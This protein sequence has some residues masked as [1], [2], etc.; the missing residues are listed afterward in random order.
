MRVAGERR[1]R[2]AEQATA[3]GNQS[4]RFACMQSKAALGA[5]QSARHGARWRS[6]NR[7]TLF[8]ATRVDRNISFRVRCR[9]R[10]GATMPLVGR[11]RARPEP[12]KPHVVPRN[13]R[14]A[15][16]RISRSAHRQIGRARPAE[17]DRTVTWREGT[18]RGRVRVLPEYGCGRHTV[19]CCV[20]KN[21]YPFE[22]PSGEAQ[23]TNISCARCPKR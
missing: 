16:R 9:D 21:G 19:K 17:C 12:S 23:P 20:L 8:C 15:M 3:S 11:D 7:G 22:W 13:A 10:S 18:T 6:D 1:R 5:P 4:M 2:V 14:C